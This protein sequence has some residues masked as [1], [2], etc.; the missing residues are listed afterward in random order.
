MSVVFLSLFFNLEVIQ[1]ANLGNHVAFKH[2]Q[3]LEN[4]I[5]N[6]LKEK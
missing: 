4:F 2:F 3:D 1:Q 5:L 6:I